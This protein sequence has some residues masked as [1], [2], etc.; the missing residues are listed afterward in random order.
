M[1]GTWLWSSNETRARTFSFH[2]GTVGSGLLPNSLPILIQILMRE[3]LH[4]QLRVIIYISALTGK[5]GRA[6][7]ISIRLSGMGLSGLT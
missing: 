3:D 6:G 5:E 7:M 2:P 4:F 1:E